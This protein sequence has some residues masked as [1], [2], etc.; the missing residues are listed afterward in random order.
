MYVR[1]HLW[2]TQGDPRWSDAVRR[3]GNPLILVDHSENSGAEASLLADSRGVRVFQDAVAAVFL[4][5][6]EPAT[7]LDSE[8]AFPTIDFGAKHFHRSL[9]TAAPDEPGAGARRVQAMLLVHSMLAYRQVDSWA[10]RVPIGLFAMDRARD[11]IAQ[12]PDE[13]MAWLAL[14]QSAPG[15]VQDRDPTLAGP[16]DPGSAYRGLR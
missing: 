9:P 2:L 4:A 1:I 6:G 10:I 12:T 7:E 8:R 13:P 14:G 16:W 11:A 3:I 15:L 5:R